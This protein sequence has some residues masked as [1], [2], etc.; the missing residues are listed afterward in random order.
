M[1]PTTAHLQLAIDELTG[2]H[3]HTPYFR[4]VRVDDLDA[5]RS[6]LALHNV[7]KSGTDPL[8]CESRFIATLALLIKRYAD[9]H[10]SEQPLG[11][12]HQAVQQVKRYIEA[13]FAQRISLSELAAQVMLSPYYLLRVFRAGVGLPPHAY[14]QDV[15]I[16]Q[17]Q[18][19]IEAGR[20]L[21][22]VAFTVGYSSQSHL[23][24]RFKQIVGVT[25][26]QYA[27]QIEPY[28]RVGR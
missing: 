4:K 8:E 14:L 26:G 6:V 5:T 16:R 27:A 12:E 28:R 1:Y 13:N 7:L 21:A 2:R 15:R 11:R 17:A 22:D 24:R 18:R 20:S 25:P 3:S 10:P 23:T 19:L 9:V